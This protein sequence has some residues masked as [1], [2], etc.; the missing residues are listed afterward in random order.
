[1][2]GLLW[3]LTID[4]F[5]VTIFILV[6]TAYLTDELSRIRESQRIHGARL[7]NLI[8]RYYRKE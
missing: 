2:T 3:F 7:D 4:L 1:M 5:I 6:L 8:A